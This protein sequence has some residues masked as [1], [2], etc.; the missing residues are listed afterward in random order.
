M[1]NLAITIFIVLLIAVVGLKFVS[2]QVRETES[3]LV[4]RLGKPVRE[5]Q[6]P[7]LYFKW[8]DPI[9]R[10]DK[11][12]SRKRVLEAEPGE[13][14]T[15][16]AQPIIV[17]TYVVWK[18]DKPREFFNRLTT[19]DQA[20][21]ILRSQIN[22]TQNKVVGRYRFSEFVNSDPAMIKTEQIQRDMLTDL[23][24]SIGEGYGI[25]IVDLGIKQLKINEEV[26]KDVFERMKAERISETAKI[27]AEGQTKGAQI[28]AE[29]DRKRTELLAAAEAR[30][31]VIRADG[32]A[33]AAKYY[34]LLDE[35]PEFAMFLRKIEALKKIMQKRATYVVPTNEAPFDLLKEIPDI[36]PKK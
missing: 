5:I 34:K 6:E 13:T 21:T 3:A 22:D 8:P 2:F 27:F 1:K 32:D 28:K 16:G 30:A 14:T 24:G 23:R 35:D 7:G 10:K 11:F 26:T 9:E 31:A 25:E 33:E 12:D 4:T 15:R 18:I 36:E 19:V 20:E 29:A 17:Q